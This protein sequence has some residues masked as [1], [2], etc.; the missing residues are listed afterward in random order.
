LPPVVEVTWKPRFRANSAIPTHGFRQFAPVHFFDR[1]GR[2][3]AAFCA[4]P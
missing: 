3:A 4:A 2:F 1:L